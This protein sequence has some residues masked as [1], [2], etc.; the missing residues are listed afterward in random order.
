MQI[1]G[2]ETISN[3]LLT[4]S[5][6]IRKMSDDVTIVLLESYKRNDANRNVQA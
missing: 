4:Q 2:S 6:E 5:I 3:H 1:I